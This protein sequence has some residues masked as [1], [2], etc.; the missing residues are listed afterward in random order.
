MQPLQGISC[1]Q[2]LAA[3]GFMPA[4]RVIGVRSFSVSAR[5]LF[6]GVTLALIHL[7]SGDW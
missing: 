7:A 3:A 1:F 5:I 6:L 2:L 4:S